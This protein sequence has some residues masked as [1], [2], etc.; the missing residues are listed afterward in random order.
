[1]PRHQG[2]YHEDWDN[3]QRCGF[4]YPIS[5]LTFQLGL[6]VCTKTC[7]DNLDVMYRPLAIS[8]VF[9]SDDREFIRDKDEQNTVTGWDDLYF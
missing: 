8:R 1:M 9:E 2:I 5:M 4:E 3:C 7:V 6:K